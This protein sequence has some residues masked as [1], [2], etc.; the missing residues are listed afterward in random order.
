MGSPAR[1][2]TRSAFNRALR[3]IADRDPM[4]VG[5]FE[6]AVAIEAI[7]HAQGRTFSHVGEENFEVR[8]PGRADANA[9]RAEIAISR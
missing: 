5:G 7:E 9:A 2:T 4:A 6:V 3:P 1:P 8:L